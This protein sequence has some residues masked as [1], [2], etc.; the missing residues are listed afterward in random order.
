M[1]ATTLVA[2][3]AQRREALQRA[4]EVRAARAAL[5]RQIAAGE[6]SAAEAI[7]SRESEIGGMPIVDVLISQPS[8]GQ[9]RC[10]RFLAAISLAEN[11][12]IVSMTDRQR[13]LVTTALCAG[14]H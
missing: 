2:G 14:S 13:T 12:T 8:W 7:L 5:K 3:S 11:K 1:S 6:L 10:Q 9:V 4:N